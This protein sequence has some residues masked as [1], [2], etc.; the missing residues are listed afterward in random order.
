ML[1]SRNPQAQRF[2]EMTI[3]ELKQNDVELKVYRRNIDPT[4][5]IDGYFDDIHM[6]L[7]VRKNRRWL[8]TFV[9]EYAH[10]L[11]WKTNDPTFAAYYKYDYN[12]IQLVEMWLTRRVAYDRRVKNSFRVIRE[13]E[14]ACDRLATHLIQKHQLPINLDQYRRR[15]NH[16]LLFY[17]CVEQKRSWNASDMF[18]GNRLYRLIPST[19]RKSY[20]EHVPSKLMETALELF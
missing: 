2:L 14:M 13:N 7:A 3:D 11:Q 20:T 8:E 19:I 9:H 17:H 1:Q 10:F 5:P 12:P 15:A 6:Q 18:Y 4:F 16:Q